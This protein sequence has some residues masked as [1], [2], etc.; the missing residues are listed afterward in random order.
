MTVPAEL[1]DLDEAV[2][3]LRGAYARRTLQNLAWSGRVRYIGRGERMRFLRSWLLDDLLAH[4]RFAGKENDNAA[5]GKDDSWNS[6][7]EI[8]SAA[9]IGASVPAASDCAAPKNNARDAG[10]K[11]RL[12]SRSPGSSRPGDSASSPRAGASKT[13]R[14]FFKGRKPTTGDSKS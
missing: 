11:P 7:E 6:E 2:E 14:K 13:R 4:S 8:P 10:G 12:A 5:Q 1:L 9:R 3:Y